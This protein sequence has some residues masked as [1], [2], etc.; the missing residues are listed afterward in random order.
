MGSS[1]ML[2]ISNSH[3]LADEVIRISRRRDVSGVVKDGDAVDVLFVVQ[4]LESVVDVLFVVQ[5]LESVGKGAVI[6]GCPSKGMGVGEGKLKPSLI[7]HCVEALTLVVI[8]LSIIRFLSYH[9]LWYYRSSICKAINYGVDI[10]SAYVG[11][12]DPISQTISNTAPSLITVGAAAVDRG[13]PPAITLGNIALWMVLQD[14]S[15]ATIRSALVTTGDSVKRATVATAMAAIFFPENDNDDGGE[16]TEKKYRGVR[17]GRNGNWAAE[18]RDTKNKRRKW[19]GTFATAEDAAGAYDE[20]AIR[21]RGVKTKLNFPVS[22]YNV[23]EILRLQQMDN[24]TDRGKGNAFEALVGVT[25]AIVEWITLLEWSC[26]CLDADRRRASIGG[27]GRW[28]RPALRDRGG[29]IARGGFFAYGGVASRQIM[30][31]P[32]TSLREKTSRSWISFVIK[33]TN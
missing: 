14:W 21:F 10:I 16:R 23:E 32:S 33:R 12:D 2:G 20:A 13:F 24:E 25:A 26:D 3:L 7:L 11:N 17:Q 29:V 9:Y 4:I 30:V 18:I 6:K 1:Y 19:L 27:E 8:G 15:S 28:L 5:I 31:A 22:N